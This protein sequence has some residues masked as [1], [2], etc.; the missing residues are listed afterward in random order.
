[1]SPAEREWRALAGRLRE[2]AQE[3]VS[4]ADRYDF[5]ADM[6][7]LR[8]SLSLTEVEALQRLCRRDCPD[9]LAAE[10]RG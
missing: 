8:E 3:L 2:R 6:Q 4:H 9:A 1:M 7:A 5:S 10:G